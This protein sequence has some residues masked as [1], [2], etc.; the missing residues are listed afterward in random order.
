MDAEPRYRPQRRVAAAEEAGRLGRLPAPQVAG[1]LAQLTHAPV[2]AEGSTIACLITGNV[3]PF[4]SA[5]V[6]EHCA[7]IKAQLER[8][9]EAAKAKQEAERAAKGEDLKRRKAEAT[10]EL[11]DL[12]A[13]KAR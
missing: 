8:N 2:T 7:A 1:H 12:E 9:A 4:A 13:R 11:A 3:A 5:K 10:R 6:R